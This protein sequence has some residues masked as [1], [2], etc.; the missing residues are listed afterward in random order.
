VVQDLWIVLVSSSAARGSGG[1]GSAEQ[2]T[3]NWS[4]SA[5]VSSPTSIPTASDGGAACPPRGGQRAQQ[6]RCACAV[7]EGV[8]GLAALGEVVDPCGE[9][10]SVEEHC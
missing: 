6:N 1:L 9:L 10:V 7:P 5:S 4:L 8:M 2:F 3:L